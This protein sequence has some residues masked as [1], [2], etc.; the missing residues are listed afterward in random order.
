MSTIYLP[1]ARISGLEYSNRS[2]T[3]RATERPYINSS[4]ILRTSTSVLVMEVQYVY[5]NATINFIHSVKQ[6]TIHTKL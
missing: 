3:V 2:M 4:I 1:E 5:F 6:L